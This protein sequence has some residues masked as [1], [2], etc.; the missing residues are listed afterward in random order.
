MSTNSES[1]PI[2]YPLLESV[3]KQKGLHLQGIY[4]Y[5]DVTPI[6]DASVRTIQQW[7]RDGKL[8]C[9]DMP[10]R[11]K[12]LSEDLEAFLRDSLRRGHDDK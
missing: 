11:G 10:G 3:L 6:F 7:V 9:R 2:R 12:F 5:R 4:K 8:Q 1:Q